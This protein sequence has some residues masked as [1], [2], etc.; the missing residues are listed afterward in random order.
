[1]SNTNNRDTEGALRWIV[2][3]LKKH[4]ITFQIEGGFAS[5]LYGATRE[6]ADIDISIGEDKFK[7]LTEEIQEY[8]TYGPARYVDNE[9]DLE[10]ITLQ[11]KGQEI[12]IFSGYDKKNFNKNTSEWVN[13]PSNFKTSVFMDVYGIKVPVIA[14]EDLLAYKNL[15]L[16]EVDI[17]DI[18]ELE[19]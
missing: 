6:L 13:V 9:W 16:R 7:E 11:Y 15:I 1:M 3:I 19:N 4:N 12:D 17:S 2:G 14:K 8:I 10:L 18:K 5:R